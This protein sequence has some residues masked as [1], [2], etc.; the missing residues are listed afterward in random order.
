MRPPARQLLLP[1]HLL[2]LLVA[3]ALL[4]MLL[5]RLGG[6]GMEGHVRCGW[7]AGSGKGG[8]EEVPGSQGQHPRMQSAQGRPLGEEW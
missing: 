1:Q 6:T 8:Q 5:L 2:L 7:S 4:Q 3:H